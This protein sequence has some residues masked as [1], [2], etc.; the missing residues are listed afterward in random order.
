MKRTVPLLVLALTVGISAQA[1]WTT[2]LTTNTYMR[3]VSSGDV[4]TPQVA[5]GPDGSTYSCWFENNS[6]HG[7][8][9][10]MQR[11]DASGNRMWPD[12]ALVVSDQ[13]QN[14]AIF[15]YQMKS[16]ADGNA[17]VAFQ[18]ERTGSLDIVAYKIGPDESFLWGANGIELPTP[19]TTGLAPVV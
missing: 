10:R 5:D 8:Q 9:L 7:Y 14:S 18:D 13:P 1:Q 12:T 11:L 2:D 3:A 16:D 4:N 19:G 15:R 17:V 6:E